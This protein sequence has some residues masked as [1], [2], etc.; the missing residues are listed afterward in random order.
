MHTF[1]TLLCLLT[2]T[3]FLTQAAIPI[4]KVIPHEDPAP[5]VP[6]S[7]EGTAGE[8]PYEAPNESPNEGYG[9][10]PDDAVPG[11]PQ[12]GS[13]SS[14]GTT[15]EKES[16]LGENLQ[17]V[18][19][20]I[21]S[22][23][24]LAVSTDSGATAT[25]MPTVSKTGSDAMITPAPNS[26]PS[27]AAACLSANSVYNS[28]SQKASSTAIPGLG[29][30]SLSKS[31]QA[32]CLCYTTVSSSVWQWIPKTFDGW[33]SQCQTWVSESYTASSN[34]ATATMQAGVVQTGIFEGVGLCG[35][36]GN[37]MASTTST[38]TTGMPA[39]ATTS[40]PVPPF[41]GEACGRE[42]GRW[43]MGVALLVGL[44]LGWGDGVSP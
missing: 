24:E 34:V 8:S 37:V 7:G 16:D 31:I 6:T 1:T 3:T 12:S 44:L 2:T 10:R 32:S 11:T 14:D 27:N 25:P 43:G 18:V 28:C 26:L 33:M 9:Y 36:A 41:V 40:A 39:A 13:G 38:T 19:D 17:D 23:I 35:S 29:F 5:E 42:V 15:E 21:T 20:L 4:P 22:L 30:D